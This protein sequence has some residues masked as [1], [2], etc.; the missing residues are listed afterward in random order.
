MITKDRILHLCKITNIFMKHL[1]KQPKLEYGIEV[2]YPFD[3]PKAKGLAIIKFKKI[4]FVAFQSAVG[5]HPKTEQ[6]LYKVWGPNWLPKLKS[7]LAGHF[8][9][10]NLRYGF[11]SEPLGYTIL[12]Y[13]FK[14]E[15]T[16]SDFY[17]YLERLFNESALSA[18]ICEQLILINN[19]TKLNLLQAA[20][21]QHYS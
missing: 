19:D 14:K 3:S 7:V 6:G 16:Q 8:H 9:G 1:D 20:K 12:I 5:I 10:R 17:S 13:H 18:M 11:S 21:D 2:K 15:L 4:P